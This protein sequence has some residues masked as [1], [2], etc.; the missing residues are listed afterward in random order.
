MD[1]SQSIHEILS[2]QDVVTDL[3]YVKYLDRYPDV[4]NYFTNVDMAQQAVLLRMALTVVAQYYVDRYP[5][6]QQ[7]LTVLG[8][9]HYLRN[10]PPDLYADWRDCLLDTL[11]QFHG[12]DWNEQL[13][14]EWTEAVNLATDEILKGYGESV[15]D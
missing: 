13:E 3:F 15:L 2:R 5:A 12:N 1:I 14:T 6:A 8:H 9:K 11:E 10:I 4:R 7:Y